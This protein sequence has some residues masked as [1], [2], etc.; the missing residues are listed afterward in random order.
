MIGVGDVQELMLLPGNSDGDDVVLELVGE[1]PGY[2]ASR[3]CASIRTDSDC[4]MQVYGPA[5]YNLRPRI[6]AE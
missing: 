2:F 1:D 5:V 4:G 6:E 3:D